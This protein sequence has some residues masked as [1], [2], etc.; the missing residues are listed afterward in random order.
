[1]RKIFGTLAALSSLALVGL[2]AA[3]VAA[4]V[5]SGYVGDD[6]QVFISES[7]VVGGNTVSLDVR[8]VPDRVCDS[9]TVSIDYSTSDRD[10]EAPI[11]PSTETGG[12][13]SAF[14]V[15]FDTPP[16]EQV[17]TQT[18]VVVCNYTP[19]AAAPSVSE[20]ASGVASV[21]PAS[22]SALPAVSQ[23]CGVGCV[24]NTNTVTLLPLDAAGADRNGILPGTGG[25]PMW[26]LVLGGALVIAG[27]AAAV[28][29]RRR[30]S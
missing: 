3:P 28:M 29:A 5:Q 22:Y 8:T 30:S 6:Q 24:T 27:V 16:V 18:N 10:I 7:T 21:T 19:A 11:P 20:S 12:G 25:A 26:L 1:M 14:S 23:S 9:W 4:D 2:S 15:T 13:E 17:T